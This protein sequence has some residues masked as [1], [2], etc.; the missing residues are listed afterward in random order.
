MSSR[1]AILSRIAKNKPQHI[2]PPDISILGSEQ[3]TPNACLDQFCEVAKGIGAKVIL[4]ND[5]SEVKNYIQ[6][7]VAHNQRVVSS[8]PELIDLTEDASLF[9]E[10]IPHELENVEL[11][12]IRAVLGVA[13][14]GA[15]W[16][17]AAQMGTRVLPF[18]TQHLAIIVN[19]ADI[20]SDMHEAYNRTAGSDHDFAAF[21]AGPSKTAD[22]EQS[23]VLGAHGSRSLVVFVL[24]N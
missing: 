9:I 10:A 24:N 6:N 23:L 15:L 19:A 12:V 13:E 5:L 7:R 14:N 4:I 22:I 11:A 16:V 18:I 8:I 2:A 17:T 1:A 20:V 3:S 21:I